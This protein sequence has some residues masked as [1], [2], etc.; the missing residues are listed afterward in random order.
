MK[1][2][3]SRDIFDNSKDERG[4]LEL[5]FL[6]YL[7]TVKKCYELLIDD[8]DI[9]SSDYMK[10]MGDNET[11]IFEWAFTQAMTSSAKCDCQISKSERLKRRTKFLPAKRQSCI[12][13]NLYPFWWRTA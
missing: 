7:I 1:V 4:K 10:G 3:I 12:F 11:R 9:L 6:I 8:S 13:C 5:N 2:L